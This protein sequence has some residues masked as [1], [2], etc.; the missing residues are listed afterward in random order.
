[1]MKQTHQQNLTM[2]N[3]R[4]H[5]EQKMKDKENKSHEHRCQ[6]LARQDEP[7]LL[8]RSIKEL[9][10]CIEEIPARIDQIA[11]TL[12][13]IEAHIDKQLNLPVVPV[14]VGKADANVK[15]GW[16]GWR[17][18]VLLVLWAIIMWVLSCCSHHA[19]RLF[20]NFAGQWLYDNWRTAQVISDVIQGLGAR[21]H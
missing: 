3:I 11:C 7:A 15:R 18:W 6:R 12:K 20:T 16:R 13:K 10:A 2:T 5:H 14:A 4:F 17:G 19:C 8:G 1:M 21:A 9:P